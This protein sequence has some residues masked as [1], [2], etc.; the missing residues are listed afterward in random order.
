MATWSKRTREHEAD[1]MH[2]ADIERDEIH[3][4]PLAND[5]GI[6]ITLE[7]ILWNR[8][9][10]ARALHGENSSEN[11]CKG[12][13]FSPPSAHP[14]IRTSALP[15]IRTSALPHIRTS[16]LP[17]IRTSALPCI[18]TANRFRSLLNWKHCGRSPATLPTIFIVYFYFH[19]YIWC[20]PI[21]PS[22]IIFPSCHFTF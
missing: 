22:V 16:A 5:Q 12:T 20:D 3:I 15:H 2:N 9:G 19:F 11:A 17:H 6:E 21:T 10:N 14:H 13:V 18:R 7:E 1:E 4:Q 8:N